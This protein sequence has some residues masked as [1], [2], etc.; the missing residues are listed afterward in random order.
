M[1]TARCKAFLYAAEKGSLSRAADELGYTP[2]GVSQLIT[3]LEDDLGFKLL[4][5]T[6]K[7]V[8]LT[9]AGTQMLP[10]IRQFITDEA[11]IYEKASDIKGLAVGEVT[12]CSYPSI[13]TY[14]LPMLIQRFQTD[15]PQIRIHLMEGILQEIQEWV[16]DGTADMGFQTNQ[17][18]SLFEWTPLQDDRM[19]A[20]LPDHHPL[21]NAESY[22]ISLC[23]EEDFI[24]PALGN[25]MD[26]KELLSRFDIDPNIKFSTMENPVMLGLI[27]SG[28]GM[29]I[30]NE[31]ST[32]AW[33]DQ[34]NIL[35]L[36]PDVFVTYGIVTPKARHIS[37]A[38]EKFREYA[39]R[40]LTKKKQTTREKVK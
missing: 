5:R 40:M 15:Y 33:A 22:P 31:L 34:L 7:G 12:I 30:M 19:V 6:K 38:A 37:P 23:K 16:L 35:P 14:L 24:M 3:A 8:T 4:Q 9:Q 36:K 2:S 11:A 21:A 10:I 28:L 25:D 18:T 39:V 20:V 32:T 1:E 29:S 17:S 26:V 13:A 27:K